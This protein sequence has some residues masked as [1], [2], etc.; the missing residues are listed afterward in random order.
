MSH[1]KDLLAPRTVETDAEQLFRERFNRLAGQI[2]DGLDAAIRTRTAPAEA[3]KMRQVMRQHLLN[4]GLSG[5]YAITLHQA[6]DT[7]RS[8][9]D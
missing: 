4:A 3:Q 8:N 2:V 7:T 1:P 9:G 5:L 6:E